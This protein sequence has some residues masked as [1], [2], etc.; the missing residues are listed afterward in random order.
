VATF[1]DKLALL[2]TANSTQ[3]VSELRKVGSSAE[4]N[5]SKAERSGTKFQNSLTA[6]GAVAPAVGAGLLAF[7]AIAVKTALDGQAAHQRLEVA[8]TNVGQ[9]TGAWE[10]QIASVSDR[11]A[12][13]G[14]NNVQVESSI[15]KLIPAT[16]NVGASLKLQGLAADIARG[17]NISLADA[18]DILVKV[19]QGRYTQLTRAGVLSTNQVKGFKD[20][21]DALKAL[22]RTYGGDASAFS[23]T[24]AGNFATLGAEAHNVAQKV[25]NDLAPALTLGLQAVNALISGAEKGG[26]FLKDLGSHLPG[27]A[28]N[29]FKKP[30]DITTSDINELKD[31]QS[32]YAEVVAQSGAAAAKTSVEH[33]KLLDAQQRVAVIQQQVTDAM[34]AGTDQAGADGGAIDAVTTASQQL[35][36]AQQRLNNDLS[37]GKN[38]TADLAQDRKDLV[39]ATLFA[40]QVEHDVAAATAQAQ[41]NADLATGSVISLADAYVILGQSASQAAATSVQNLTNAAFSGFDATQSV[42]SATDQYASAL[43]NL[44]KKSGGGGAGGATK[45]LTAEYYNQQQKLQALRDAQQATGDN[46]LTLA[47]S[48]RDEKDALL[49]AAKAAKD[50]QAAL[51][52]VSAASNTALDA[53]SNVGATK[54]AQRSAQLDVKDATAAYNKA[55]R[56]HGKG[57]EAAQRAEIALHD[58]RRSLTQA[59][60]DYAEAQRVLNGTLHG[61]A[62]GSPEVVTAAKNL[63]DAQDK[64][65]DSIKTV[66]ENTDSATDSQVAL[67]RALADLQGKLDSIKTG[68]ASKQVESFTSKLDAVKSAAKTLAQDVGQQVTTAT[69]S[70]GQGLVAE[71]GTLKSI[72]DQ[73]PALKGAFDGVLKNLQA[74]LAKYLATAP[75]PARYNPNPSAP[76]G[77]VHRRAKGGPVNAMQPYWVGEVGP[78]LFVPS[79]NGNIVPHGG[80]TGT[81]INIGSIS[82]DTPRGQRVLAALVAEIRSGGNVG[83]L[84]R[85][86][87]IPA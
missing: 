57:S 37:S 76:V 6:I 21:N 12:K 72:I 14:F 7:G 45:N 38:S 20:Q 24:L 55:V 85:A 41:A 8:I 52:G 33:Q 11:M 4:T 80:S 83:E 19:E 71:I 44:T 36:A 32:K 3:A 60:K 87:S 30:G 2:I 82:A 58:A 79:R 17:R 16:K 28:P 66:R 10:P 67:R 69:G 84:K 73:Q 5:L 56:E 49:D 68:G 74:E 18:T 35:S 42:S 54:D 53:K 51:H 29:A 77:G 63:R 64:V 50:Y 23:K 86:M 46:L 1:S 43:D 40:A 78:E 75:A 59:T 26:S 48:Q 31:A 15:A 39:T 13:L 27:G 70:V 9:A 81:V 61:Y 25:G 47:R 34:K 62:A 65:A 22:S